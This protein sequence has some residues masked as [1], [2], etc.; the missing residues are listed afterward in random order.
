MRESAG[1]AGVDVKTFRKWT[2]G[3][4]NVPYAAWAMLLMHGGFI[5]PPRPDLKYTKFYFAE[6]GA[7]FYSVCFDAIQHGSFIAGD[8]FEVE[9]SGFPVPATERPGAYWMRTH[10]NFHSGNLV[11]VIARP[12]LATD[13]IQPKEILSDGL[14]ENLR[15]S[16][17][18]SGLDGG[19][20]QGLNLQ[21]GPG[22]LK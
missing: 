4:R 5:S 16:M 22:L 13:P 20:D 6:D 3:E 12:E 11:S 7:G 9:G 18:W 15:H 1:I 10:W 21:S 19:Q 8:D 2:G 14:R 17:Q